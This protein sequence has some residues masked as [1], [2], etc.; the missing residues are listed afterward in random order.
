AHALL[1]ACL[2]PEEAREPHGIEISV[3]DLWRRLSGMHAD[4]AHGIIPD[5]SGPLDVPL[6]N[7]LR[8]RMFR[9]RPAIDLTAHRDQRGIFVETAKVRGG[10]GQTSYS[11]TESG[12]TR[13]EHYHLRK[14][15]RFVVISGT[16]EILIRHVLDGPETTVKLEVHGDKPMAVDMPTGWAHNITNI[17]DQPLL[18]QFWINEVYDP[19]DPDTFAERV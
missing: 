14:I 15:E 16:A 1:H 13:G 12:I 4:Y 2:H 10:G 6:F 18:T 7:T 3:A 8:A 9:D 11:T 17:G 19:D 5:L